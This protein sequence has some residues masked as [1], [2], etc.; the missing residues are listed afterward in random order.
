MCIL[1]QE[2]CLELGAGNWGT[3]GVGELTAPPCKELIKEER[4]KEEE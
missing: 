1:C 3:I 4:I 2:G